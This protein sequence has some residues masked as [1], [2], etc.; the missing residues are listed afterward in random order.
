[1]R[2]KTFQYSHHPVCTQPVSPLSTTLTTFKQLL[3]GLHE[4]E[5]YQAACALTAI[6][7]GPTPENSA[8]VTGIVPGE[9]DSSRGD[10]FG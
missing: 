9:E 5:L 3:L 7:L 6:A 10:R 1:M 2:W 8:Q 4:T